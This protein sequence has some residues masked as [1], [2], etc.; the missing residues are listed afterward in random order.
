[1]R[2]RLLA[3]LRDVIEVAAQ[4]GQQVGAHLRRHVGQ[5]GGEP[6]FERGDVGGGEAGEV[7][8]GAVAAVDDQGVLVGLEAA[9]Q[10]ID[11]AVA[12][13]EDVFDLAADLVGVGDGGGGVVIEAG[14]AARGIALDQW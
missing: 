13:A 5:Q 11:G 7:E 4:Q 12:A 10:R 2:A 14:A 8:H 3:H 1:M 9:D 6:R